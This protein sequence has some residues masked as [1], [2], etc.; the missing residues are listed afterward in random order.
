[1]LNESLL[2]PLGGW[3]F[4]AKRY[5]VLVKDPRF[6]AMGSVM[7]AWPWGPNIHRIEQ[8]GKH[9]ELGELNTLVSEGKL[10]PIEKG[11]PAPEQKVAA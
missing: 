6:P 1:M 11:K 9:I 4:E 5:E 10:R 7:A 3:N 8:T 2:K